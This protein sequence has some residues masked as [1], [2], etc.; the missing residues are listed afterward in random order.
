MAGGGIDPRQPVLVGAAALNQ[1]GT[2]A[3]D[4]LN[5]L[6]LTVAAALQ[7][8]ADAAGSGLG[9]RVGRIYA[10]AGLTKLRNP[11]A[12]VAAAVGAPSAR[13]VL[14]VPGIAQ[15][16][17]INDAL[18]AIQ[19]G[20]CDAALLCG[21]ETR[22]RDDIARRRGIELA[23]PDEPDCDPDETWKPDPGFMARAEVDAGLVHP[24]RQYAMIDNARRAALGWTIQEHRD[25]ISVLWSQ[26]STVS[27]GNPDAAFGGRRTAHELREPSAEN[28]PLAFP[29]NK[30][31]VSQWSVDQASALVFASAATAQACG[32]PRD[33]WIFPTVALESSHALSLSQRLEMHRWPAMGVLGAAASQHLGHPLAEVTLQELYSCFPAA[34]RVQQAEL[35]LNAGSVPTMTGGMT[36]A[37]GPLNNFVF[38]ST[39]AMSHKIRDG[40]VAGLVTGVSGLLTKPGLGVYHPGP[41]DMPM[42]V[43]DLAAKASAATPS[44]PLAEEPDGSGKV[45]AYTVTYDGLDPQTL[46]AVVDLDDAAGRAIATVT[47]PVLASEATETEL[48]GAPCRIE[49]GLLLLSEGRRL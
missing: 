36:F 3:G 40:D 18:A 6:E 19:S 38:H 45:A 12:A 10:A 16:A 2:E 20:R 5:T 34:V 46:F 4:G 29:Y 28:R 44:A 25:D 13:T 27:A 48:I 32:V 24:V 23:P 8:V 43:A 30:W 37:G 39:A 15:Q 49:D 14:A 11:A 35:G 42:L 26:F 41:V 33:R 7:A 47:D 21:G 17:M 31:L 1:R 9:R 22:R